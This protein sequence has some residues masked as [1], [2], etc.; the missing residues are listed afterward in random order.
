MT[1]QLFNYKN[2]LARSFPYFELI[3]YFKIK[4]GS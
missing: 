4:N 3:T 1:M 2:T